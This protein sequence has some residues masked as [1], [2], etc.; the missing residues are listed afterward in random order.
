MLIGKVVGDLTSVY[1]WYLQHRNTIAV[2]VP[3]WLFTL[4]LP[5][6]SIWF[7][8]QQVSTGYDEILSQNFNINVGYL[9]VSWLCIMSATILGAWEWTLLV[10]ALGGHL[11]IPEGMQIHLLANLSKYV[12]GS[13]WPYIGKAYLASQKGVAIDIA[14]LSLVFE[15]LIVFF[16]GGLVLLMTLPFSNVFSW[17]VMQRAALQVGTFLLIGICLGMIPTL[18]NRYWNKVNRVYHPGWLKKLSGKVCWKRVGFVAIA[19]FLTWCLLGVG[20][21]LLDASVASPHWCDAPIFVFALAAAL[22][23]GQLA[24]FV[25]MGVGVREAV[26]VALL[27]SQREASLV[28]VISILLRILMM[29]GEIVSSVSSLVFVRFAQWISHK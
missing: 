15:F 10:N 6:V 21:V 11:D 7:I 23:I 24:L 17:S 27:A 13:V 4:G 3:Q 12:P 8:W 14:G 29:A 2:R 5:A 22:M 26:L 25:P 19:V 16:G 28:V 18:G 20:F 1:Q 9:V